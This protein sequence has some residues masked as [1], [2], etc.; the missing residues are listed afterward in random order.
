MEGPSLQFHGTHDQALLA[1]VL[2][3]VVVIL[4]G[5]G[6]TQLAGR[7]WR[8][9]IITL[10]AALGPVTAAAALLIDA[11]RSRSLGNG[12]SARASLLA[13]LL[14]IAGVGL[15]AALVI[16]AGADGSLWMALLVLE[17]ILAVGVFYSAVYTY[18]GTGRIAVLMALRCLAIIS[19]M[20]VL[21]KPVLSQTSSAQ[22]RPWLQVLVDRSASMGT[23]DESALPDRYTQALQMLASQRP[24]I[25]RHFGPLWRH[26]AVSPQSAETLD[27]LA[28][29]TPAGEGTG[30]T[31]L[32]LAIRTAA[33][34]YPRS[35]QAGV[36]LVSDGIHNMPD[37]YI[38]AA[39]ESG[40][41]IYTVGVG[42]SNEKSLG[43]KNLQMVSVEA[44]LEAVVNNI[45][46][47]KANVRVTGYPDASVQVRLAEEGQAQPLSQQVS[48][49]SGPTAAN[50]SVVFRW[51]PRDAASQP[52]ATTA[53]GANVRKLKLSIGPEPGEAVADDNQT[54]VHVLLTQPRIRVVYVEGT[55]RPEYRSLKRFCETDP[56][57][58]FMGLVRASGN[59]FWAQGGIAGRQLAA[60]PT[61]DEDFK[62]FDVLILGDLDRT[63]LTDAQIA[64]IRKFVND[65]G[66]LLMLGGH[67]SFGPGGYSD[68]PIEQ[69]LPVTV[70]NRSAP[71]ETATFVPQ[72]TAAGQAHPIF[73]GIAGFFLGPDGQKPRDDLPQLPELLG[74]VS[75][76]AAKPAAAV[77]AVHPSRKNESGP[78]TVLAVQQFGAGRS[79]AFTADTTRL[80]DVPMRA[81]GAA[82]PYQRFWGQLIRHLAGV[83]TKARQS[84]PAVVL[85]LESCYAQVGDVV[86]LLVRVQDAKGLAPQSAQVTVAVTDAAGAVAKEEIPMS[87][88]GRGVFDGLYRPKKDGL[89]KLT[90]VAVDEAK[91]FLGS[92][93]LPLRVDQHLLE[94]DRLSRSDVAL[95][96][97]AAKS[98]GM[99]A[100]LSGLPDLIDRIVE[101]QKS[102]ATAAAPAQ[103]VYL[104]NF[105][106]L[107]VAFAAFLT[108][109]W[110]L[111]RS[112]QLH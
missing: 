77:L 25:A 79:A 98:G 95:Q 72:L 15:A 18:L 6:L 69:V 22:S 66:G 39:V 92:D 33:A 96:L 83:E 42:S 93:E 36:L 61:T 106:L 38:D 60:L 76:A 63:F 28:Q 4:L 11:A 9:G 85:R 47:V 37:S 12:K 46:D 104:Y 64:G 89:F 57:V 48:Q 35:D 86:N 34:E 81:L 97:I 65:G 58:E 110:L 31:N 5:W 45:T 101:R 73:D 32:A 49:G 71:Q 10:A 107:F 44:P 56:N 17:V 88:N 41:P 20:L 105:T 54:E 2:V 23:V 29:L 100:D 99:Y 111:R 67:N 14:L 16:G 68:T 8:L 1:T 94:M 50:Q 3:A 91:G 75:V 109:E 78:L 21:F 70:G 55:I 82:S 52:A 13:G 51:T 80:W 108:G 103:V 27:Q 62:L 26:F 7:R 112:W 84:S 24:R 59:T 19:L 40:V 30:A 53:P 102:H 87:S 90:A 74:C 43:R